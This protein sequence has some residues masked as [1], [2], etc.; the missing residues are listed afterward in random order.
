MGGA[1]RQGLIDAGAMGGG[2]P[3]A[4]LRGVGGSLSGCLGRE[5]DEPG[6]SRVVPRE[7]LA[8]CEGVSLKASSKSQDENAGT[9]AW[10]PCAVAAARC[11][12]CCRRCSLSLSASTL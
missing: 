8:A 3:C 5:E 12:S 1:L 4:C 11:F 6:T 7:V 10:E 9:G 2:A